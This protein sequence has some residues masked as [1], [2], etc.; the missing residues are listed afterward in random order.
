MA[1]ADI[2]RKSWEQ[3]AD[4]SFAQWLDGRVARWKRAATTGTR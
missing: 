2:E 3:P 4:A 1:D